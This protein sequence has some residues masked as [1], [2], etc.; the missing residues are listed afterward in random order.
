MRRVVKEEHQVDLYL[1]MFPFEADQ[2]AV[3]C[4]VNVNN[5]VR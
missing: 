2:Y 5:L 4:T 1:R 3:T